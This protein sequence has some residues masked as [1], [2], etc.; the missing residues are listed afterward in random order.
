M[1]EWNNPLYRG[2]TRPPT[3]T[4]THAIHMPLSWRW[5][6]STHTNPPCFTH[7]HI[8]LSWDTCQSSDS[9]LRVFLW[10]AT[11]EWGE[12][13][14]F[15]LQDKQPATCAHPDSHTA[16]CTQQH[17]SEEMKTEVNRL[18]HR[19]PLFISVMSWLFSAECKNSG[20]NAHSHTRRHTHKVYICTPYVSMGERAYDPHE[21][22][23]TP[24]MWKKKNV[25]IV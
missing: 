14:F 10:W 16:E 2:Q 23:N 15:L 1:N 19:P 17:Q 5:L 7:A 9:G 22:T 18:S 8:L 3:H 6:T 25:V 24:H 11:Q 20:M 21:C 13:F 4:H 12:E